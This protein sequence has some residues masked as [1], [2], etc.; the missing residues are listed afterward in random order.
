[1]GAPNHLKSEDL[2]N[3][4]EIPPEN[5]P[6]V[7]LRRFEYD[8]EDLERIAAVVQGIAAKTSRSEVNHIADVCYY[9]TRLQLVSVPFVEDNEEFY[10]AA[11]RGRA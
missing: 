10:G 11:P 4:N 8:G 2:L 1:M 5:D 6:F 7:H 3:E 9:L